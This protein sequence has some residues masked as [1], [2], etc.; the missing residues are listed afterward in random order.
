MLIVIKIF[1]VREKEIQVKN[2]KREKSTLNNSELL[3]LNWK[4]RYEFMIYY[5]RESY[6]HLIPQIVTTYSSS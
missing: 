2:Q 4:Y 6:P 5:T 1:S 3:N